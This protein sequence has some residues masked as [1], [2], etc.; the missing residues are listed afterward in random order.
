MNYLD[1][2][3]E[4]LCRRLNGNLAVYSPLYGIRPP[5]GLIQHFGVQAIGV[6][7]SV[8][9]YIPVTCGNKADGVSDKI[10]CSELTNE[11]GE[12]SFLLIPLQMENREQK[13]SRLSRSKTAWFYNI[14]NKPFR[15]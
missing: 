5:H 4:L 2:S 14:K 1:I 9:N 10:M 8:H 13:S 12:I 7:T 3:D 6:F 11:Q 15:H